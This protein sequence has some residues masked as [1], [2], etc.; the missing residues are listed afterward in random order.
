MRDLLR[1]SS[2]RLRVDQI[3]LLAVLHAVTLAP[4][5]NA[6]ELESGPRG[7]VVAVLEDTVQWA[8]GAGVLVGL[9]RRRAYVVTARHVVFEGDEQLKLAVRF[10]AQPARRHPVESVAR[11]S[12]EFDLALLEVALSTDSLQDV[13]D[14]T[15]L[16]RASELH[17]G[18]I[19]YPVGCPRQDCFRP[20]VA[21]DRFL[22]HGG[23]LI[24]VQMRTIEP[25][26][27]GGALFNAEWEVVGMFWGKIQA[28]EAEAIAIDTILAL[29]PQEDWRSARRRLRRRGIPRAGFHTRFEYS[30]L[31]P[32]VSP[33]DVE[34]GERWPG[35]RLVAARSLNRVLS[36]HASYLRLTPKDLDIKSGLVGLTV[37]PFPG[38]LASIR[39]F[40]EAGVAS[41]QARIPGSLYVSDSDTLRTFRR[42]EEMA[43]GFGAGV[44]PR[45][46][47][48]PG[49]IVFGLIG[50]YRFGR[51]DAAA[52]LPDIVYGGGFGW[53]F[54]W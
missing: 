47:V 4:P 31:F 21:P 33:G 32:S 19:V 36:A 2:E 37:D 42:E 20:P 12:T 25:G 54:R 48:P 46:T 9:G 13:V 6:Q 52:S 53:G 41:V 15:R 43:L 23:G 24:R 17:F 49:F 29:M 16:A 39:F 51:P 38:A 27:S 14:F 11:L 35:G 10:A 30:T 1:R 5:V 26:M 44:V 18:D 50:Y 7:L 22:S 3:A 28:N 40:A 45:I 8:H 34:Q